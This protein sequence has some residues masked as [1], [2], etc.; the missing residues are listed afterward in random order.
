MCHSRLC[1][2]LFFNPINS[3]MK[4]NENKTDEFELPKMTEKQRMFFDRYYSNGRNATEAYRFAYNAAESSPQTVYKEAHRLL[5]YP[6]FTPYRDMR[7]NQINAEL[8]K[9]FNY[10]VIEAFNALLTAQQM[11]FDEKK[12]IKTSYSVKEKA[13]PNIQA[14]LK[15]EELKLRLLGLLK[16]KEDDTLLTT[17]FNVVVNAK[18][19]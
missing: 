5:H 17:S 1:G 7:E 2:T 11:A 8:S 12:Y 19:D 18:E 14:Y 15:A 13:A 4:E 16:D 10:G 9:Q 3:A 6:K